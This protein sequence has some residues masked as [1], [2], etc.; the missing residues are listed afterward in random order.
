MKTSIALFFLLVSAAG[1]SQ[2]ISFSIQSPYGKPMPVGQLTGSS[3]LSQLVAGYP[4]GWIREYRATQITVEHDG[5]QQ[6]A[7]GQDE[8]LA[9]GQ[10]TL[11]KTARVGDKITLRI[12]YR[13]ENPV[14]FKLQ[15]DVLAYSYTVVPDVAAGLPMALVVPASSTPTTMIA[16]GKVSEA[17]LTSS[18]RKYFMERLKGLPDYGDEFKEIATLSFLVDEKGMVSE[19][20]VKGSSGDANIDKQLVEALRTMPAWSP[21]SDKKGN[22]F[23][24]QFVLEVRNAGC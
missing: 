14:T 7:D 4:S 5:K 3:Q 18:L 15:D 21:G 22:R 19:V 12:E 10:Q 6:V 17:T 23:R 11:L 24:Q 13:K 2:P 9:V 20:K 1:F 8:R 16:N